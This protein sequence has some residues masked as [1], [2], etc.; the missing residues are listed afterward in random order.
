MA[1]KV[2][3]VEPRQITGKK[4]AQ[5]RNAGIR[6]AVDDAGSGF[7]SLKHILELRPD[8]IKLD[9]AMVSGIDTDPARRALAAAVADFAASIGATCSATAKGRGRLW[10][11]KVTYWR[12][13]ATTEWIGRYGATL[14]HATTSTKLAATTA[15]LTTAAKGSALTHTATLATTTAATLSTAKAAAAKAA[16]TAATKAAGDNGRRAGFDNPGTSVVFIE[17]EVVES[18]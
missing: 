3:T 4:V 10:V 18:G 8:V 14:A 7:A 15:E 16:F 2:L 5:L 1:R 11:G 9:R 6:L 12:T 17:L 13:I